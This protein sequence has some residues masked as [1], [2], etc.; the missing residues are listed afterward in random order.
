[1]SK[2]RTFEPA[3]ADSRKSFYG[4]CALYVD[5][6]GREALRSYKTIVMTRD[7]AGELHRHWSG[8][9]MTTARHIWSVYHVD[10]PTYREMAVEELP[11]NWRELQYAL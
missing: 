3:P 6:R 9:S 11:E 7:A 5:D 8:W 10:T 2:Y 4:K 1:M